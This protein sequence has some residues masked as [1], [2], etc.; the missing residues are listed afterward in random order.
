MPSQKPVASNEIEYINAAQSGSMK[1]S[2]KPV[3]IS[4]IIVWTSG[5]KSA[6]TRS[7]RYFLDPISFSLSLSL[8]LLLF[9]LRHICLIAD[10]DVLPSGL[11]RRWLHGCPSMD[12]LYSC[13]ERRRLHIF[14]SFFKP[15]W[16]T[17]SLRYRECRNGIV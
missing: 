16:S 7:I 12:F 4:E 10:E 14:F 15:R 6:C 11:F 1:S 3:T 9:F 17:Y 5:A 8:F 2:L 13:T